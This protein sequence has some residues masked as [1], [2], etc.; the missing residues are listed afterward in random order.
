MVH[1]TQSHEQKK[2][3]IISASRTQKDQISTTPLYQ[4]IQFIQDQVKLVI[5]SENSVGLPDVYNEYISHASKQSHDIIA[6]IHDDVSI[7]DS[8]FRHKLYQA[9][10]S[11]SIIG[12]AGTSDL[13]IGKPTLW[14]KMSPNEAHWSGAVAHPFQGGVRMTHFGTSPKDCIVLD[15][16]FI[17]ARLS[18]L[19]QHQL[20]FDS[21][22][23]FH[24]YDL[25]FCIQAH[26][27]GL[28]LTTWPIWLY[29]SSPGLASINNPIFQASEIR[30][31][32]KYV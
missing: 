12:V 3:L 8:M 15:G 9:A 27:K 4:S 19:L 2:I 26:K 7:E 25:D 16:L 14:H 5:V 10:Q 1:T 23:D 11:R 17:A 29:H 32:N 31:I 6:F 28:K 18:D 30:F 24:H 20:R 22:F 13:T 21:Q